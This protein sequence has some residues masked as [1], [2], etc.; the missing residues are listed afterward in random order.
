MIVV[1]MGHLERDDDNVVAEAGIIRLPGDFL[2]RVLN[3]SAAHLQPP[4]SVVA[5]HSQGAGR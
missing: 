3:F 5:V 4:A 1:K 2:V